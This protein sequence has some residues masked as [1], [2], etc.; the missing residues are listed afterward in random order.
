MTKALAFGIGSILIMLF[1]ERIA[2]AHNKRPAQSGTVLVAGLLGLLY[3]LGMLY[4][5]GA[6]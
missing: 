2:A 4:A 1:V 6:L 5:A 3:M